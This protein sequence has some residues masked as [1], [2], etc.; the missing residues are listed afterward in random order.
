[1]QR[2]ID[3]V[4]PARKAVEQPD[5][6]L[7]AEPEIELI[8]GKAAEPGGD[9]QQQ[10]IDEA[11]RR[12]KAGEQN[13]GFAF[14][15]GPGEDDGIEAGAVMGNE[16]VDIHFIGA[17]IVLSRSGPEKHLTLATSNPAM[18]KGS[19][20]PVERNPGRASDTRHPGAG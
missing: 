4:A 17:S 20:S 12:G 15:K 16:L 13:D 14:Q 7:A 2:D 10:R 1:M 3:A 5:A 11:L 9:Q 8:P 19:D 6:E 18:L